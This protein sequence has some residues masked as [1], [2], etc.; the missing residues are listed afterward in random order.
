M[1]CISNGI[2]SCSVAFMSEAAPFRNAQPTLGGSLSFND[3]V[4][5]KSELAITNRLAFYDSE[6]L[7]R[8][9]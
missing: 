4:Y 9:P 5:G 6:D 7:E 2:H 8:Y 1:V 3:D